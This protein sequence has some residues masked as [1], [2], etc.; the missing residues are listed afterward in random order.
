MLQGSH[1]PA[2]TVV[3]MGPEAEKLGKQK[4]QVHNRLVY[5]THAYLD[6]AATGRR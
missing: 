4:V 5:I 3:A 6:R 2:G 1:E